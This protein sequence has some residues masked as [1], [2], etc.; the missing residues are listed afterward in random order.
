[1]RRVTS[2]VRA[3]SNYRIQFEIRNYELCYA[4]DAGKKA[5]ENGR[6][7]ISIPHQIHCLTGEKIEK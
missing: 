1:M 2:N 6:R 3:K 5:Q 4:D 7:F